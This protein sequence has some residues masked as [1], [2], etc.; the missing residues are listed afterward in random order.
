LRK[1]ELHGIGK[2]AS[3]DD[4]ELME[5]FVVLRRNRKGREVGNGKLRTED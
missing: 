4:E 3:G 5:E 1:G 2:M